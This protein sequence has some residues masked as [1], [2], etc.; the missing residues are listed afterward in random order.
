M[1]RPLALLLLCSELWAAQACRIRSEWMD[2]GKLHMQ[3]GTSLILKGLVL[4]AAHVIS[5][6]QADLKENKGKEPLVYCED[7][8]AGGDGVGV[9][10]ESIACPF[11]LPTPLRMR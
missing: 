8:K 11:F 10:P 6:D 3:H 2:Q 9:R 7:E 5:L 1:I 4:T